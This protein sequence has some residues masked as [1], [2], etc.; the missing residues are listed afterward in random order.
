MGA[1]FKR[2]GGTPKKNVF[3]AQK[4]SLV[5][6]FNFNKK[7]GLGSLELVAQQSNSNEDTQ[8]PTPPL[9]SIKSTPFPSRKES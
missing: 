7:G 6:D 4:S 5:Q 2:G 3:R 8:M 9:V 1:S